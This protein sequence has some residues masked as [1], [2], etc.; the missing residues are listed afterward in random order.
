MIM[1]FMI[2]NYSPNKG[3][4][5][6]KKVDTVRAQD[7]GSMSVDQLKT[8]IRTNEQTDRKITAE[9]QYVFIVI[10]N[11]TKSWFDNFYITI[12]ACI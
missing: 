6:L 2:F 8:N 3:G 11:F 1:S 12:I 9:I 10:C 7:V 5:K 4:G